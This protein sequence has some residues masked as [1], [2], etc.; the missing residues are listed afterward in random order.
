MGRHL[1]GGRVGCHLGGGQGRDP[2]KNGLKTVHDS[3]L[4]LSVNASE[5]AGAA[6]RALLPVANEVSGSGN[7]FVRRCAYPLCSQNRLQ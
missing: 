6:L 3:R 2:S 1:Q 4:E 5:V 7:F